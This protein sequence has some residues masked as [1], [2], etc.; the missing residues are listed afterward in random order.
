MNQYQKKVADLEKQK[1][2][3]C[4]GTGKADDAGLGDIYYR[5][6]TCPICKGAG[7]KRARKRRKS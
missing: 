2:P 1:C 3:T 7:M 4:Q 5:T 6:W